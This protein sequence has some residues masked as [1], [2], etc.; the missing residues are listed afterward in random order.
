MYRR[1]VIFLFLVLVLVAVVPMAV[2]ADRS[3]QGGRISQLVEVREGRLSCWGVTIELDQ[4]TFN[5]IIT[6]E[7]LSVTD[8]KYGRDLKDLMVWEVDRSGKMLTIRFKPG[9][10]DF[11]T[12]N[13]VNI[14][15]HTSAFAR[16]PAIVGEVTWSIAT[17]PL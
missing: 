5:P 14:G 11:G 16:P 7:Q 8:G 6:S 13:V 15:V 4:T 12:G 1:H 3:R 9:R 10:G 17:D 2:P